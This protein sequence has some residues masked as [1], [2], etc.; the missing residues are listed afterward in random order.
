MSKR[1]SQKNLIYL[2]P[3]FLEHP[4]LQRKV[5]GQVKG[6]NA[7]YN[8]QLY[9][10]PSSALHSKWHRALAYFRFTIHSII[11][12]I[13]CDMTYI[14]LNAK[15]PLLLYILSKLASKKPIIIE[16]NSNY[17]VELPYLG[18][19]F[20]YKCYQWIMKKLIHSKAH[21]AF[22]SQTVYDEVKQ[23]HPHTH[24]VHFLQNGYIKDDAPLTDHEE[25]KL[26]QLITTI[27]ALKKPDTKLAVLVSSVPSPRAIDLIQVLTH[28]PTLK[29]VSIGSESLNSIHASITYIPTISPKILDHLLPYFDLGVAPQ[30]SHETGFFGGSILKT[31]AYLANG[32]PIITDYED[33]LETT[34]LSPYIFNFRKY[35]D[36]FPNEFKDWLTVE[37]DRNQIKSIA[38]PILN[39]EKILGSII[40]KAIQDH[41]IPSKLTK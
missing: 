29:L 18:R 6:L 9:A 3:S 31:C 15:Y 4:G 34:E 26:R 19:H 30:Y 5:S 38:K 16:V 27:Q 17:N 32:L 24:Q 13:Q 28:Y 10:I 14:R 2:F 7:L 21:L 12:A 22:P 25:T 8:C 20:E 23:V 39:W 35:Q 37:H 41:E 11:K 40:Q 36:Q 1:E 33:S